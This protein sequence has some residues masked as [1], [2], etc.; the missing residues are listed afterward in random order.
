MGNPFPLIIS[1]WQ[2]SSPSGAFRLVCHP[3]PRTAPSASS[4]SA[5]TYPKPSAVS[6]TTPFTWES[7][8]FF[9]PLNHTKDFA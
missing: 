2:E 5:R 8:N 9:S 3:L 6:E 1:S 4:Q 7:I